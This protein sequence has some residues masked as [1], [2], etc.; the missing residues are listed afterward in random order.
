MPSVGAVR[1]DAKDDELPLLD[2]NVNVTHRD[3]RSDDEASWPS[4]PGILGEDEA[5]ADSERKRRECDEE[6]KYHDDPLWYGKTIEQIKYATELEKSNGNAASR[7][8]PPDWKRA[9]RYWKN[10][11]R[12]AVKVEDVDT[13]LRLRLNLALGYT[14]QHKTDKALEQCDEFFCERLLVAAPPKLRA[15]A[16]FRRGEAYADAGEVSKA[17]KSF[18]AALEIEPNNADARRMLA[19]QRRLEQE[20]RARERDMFR[21]TLKIEEEQQPVPVVADNGNAGSLERSSGGAERSAGCGEGK[22]RAPADDGLTADERRIA[23][24]LTDRKASA[25]LAGLL[26]GTGS[27]VGESLNFRVGPQATFGPW[28]REYRSSSQDVPA[29]LAGEVSLSRDAADA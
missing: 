15:K 13:E 3:E 14:R 22:H 5:E 27:N 1:S 18:R 29:A 25:R 16:H 21:D 17:T 10:A 24:S 7:E 20:R 9:N 19:D 8:D 4:S 28:T 12:G 26:R 23:A 6:G 2:T 11:V